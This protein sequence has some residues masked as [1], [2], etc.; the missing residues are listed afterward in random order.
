MDM[1][2]RHTDWLPLTWA[3]IKPEAEVHVLDQTQTHDHSVCG[4][5]L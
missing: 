4:Q 2:M 5:K 1:D 3:E